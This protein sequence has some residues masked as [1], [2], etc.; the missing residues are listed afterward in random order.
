MMWLKHVCKLAID[1]KERDGDPQSVFVERF[2][3][4][5]SGNRRGFL[6]GTGSRVAFRGLS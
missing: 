2:L 3:V 5:S 6:Q 4:G 1:R